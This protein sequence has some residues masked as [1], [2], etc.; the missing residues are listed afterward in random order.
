MNCRSQKLLN[1]RLLDSLKD[2]FLSLNF[3]QP[4]AGKYFALKY[5]QQKKAGF[6]GKKL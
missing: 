4:P 1:M 3:L 2:S 5:Y 6:I